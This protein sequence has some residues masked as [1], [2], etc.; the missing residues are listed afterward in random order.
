LSVGAPRLTYQTLKVLRLFVDQPRRQMAGA[1]IARL[2]KLG[3]GTL[4][5][6]LNRFEKAGWL[7]SCWEISEPSNL[8]RPRKRLYQITGIGQQSVV[9]ALRDLGIVTGDAAWAF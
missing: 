8:G 5:P 4:Y 2:T 3:S 1:D 7:T 9:A 6:I